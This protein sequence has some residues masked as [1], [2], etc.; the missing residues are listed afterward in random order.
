MFRL[1]STL[2]LLTGRGGLVITPPSITL[3]GYEGAPPVAV[4]GQFIDSEPLSVGGI[5]GFC[6]VH[7]DLYLRKIKKNHEADRSGQ[8]SWARSA[9]SLIQ[10]FFEY[11]YDELKAKKA[12]SGVGKDPEAFRRQ[13][14][15]LLNTFTRRHQDRFRK[16]NKKVA[17][18]WDLKEDQLRLLLFNSAIIDLFHLQGALNYARVASNG[19]TPKDKQ[20]L[21]AL[22]IRQNYTPAEYLKISPQSTPDLI[23][24]K[25]GAIGD[26]KTGTMKE[27]HFWTVAGY[28]LGYESA[29]KQDV[30][31]GVVYMVD[32]ADDCIQSSRS[33]I[34]WI[35]DD[36]RKRFLDRRDRALATLK[37]AAAPK[38][39]TNRDQIDGFC[40]RCAFFSVCKPK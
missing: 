29:T 27:E 12:P 6:P 23:L 36:I 37:A 18:R 33:I 15:G 9:G 38:V 13:V 30:D 35:S 22:K 11:V 16:L 20:A 17:T 24:P 40:K 25:F 31:L 26:V 4:T 14:H 5:V 7:R 8:K 32:T 2:E 10:E 34:F 19:N 21:T 28:A 39:L 1:E 3:R